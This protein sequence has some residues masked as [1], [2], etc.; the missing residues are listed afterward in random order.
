MELGLLVEEFVPPAPR[1]CAEEAGAVIDAVLAPH[2]TPSL[3]S[4]EATSRLSLGFGASLAREV[5]LVRR[6]RRRPS[7]P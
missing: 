2:F 6:A 1:A 3:F 5:K 7:K 4:S